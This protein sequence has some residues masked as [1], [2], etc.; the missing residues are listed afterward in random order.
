M[1]L[2]TFEVINN[3]AELIQ[4]GKQ[5]LHSGSPWIYTFNFL[6]H[7]C[8]FHVPT[9]LIFSSCVLPAECIWVLYDSKNKQAI[10]SFGL[11]HPKTEVICSSKYLVNI[12]TQC[13]NPENHNHSLFLVLYCFLAIHLARILHL[14]QFIIIPSCLICFYTVYPQHS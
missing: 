3:V 14:L 8:N 5:I 12:I 6:K 9:T 13:Y 11:W 10:V 2:T 4:A 7:S 1:K